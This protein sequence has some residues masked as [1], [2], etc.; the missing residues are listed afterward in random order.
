MDKWFTNLRHSFRVSAKEAPPN[1]VPSP[2]KGENSGNIK[3]T[4]GSDKPEG[5]IVKGSASKGTKRKNSV[6][7]R[8]PKAG[9]E[10]GEEDGD[11]KNNAGKDRQKAIARELR[12]MKQGR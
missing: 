11:D 10:H 7:G 2:N 8:R 4:T 5:S 1:G 6:P 12:K 3:H 9:A